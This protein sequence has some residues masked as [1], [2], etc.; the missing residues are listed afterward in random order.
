MTQSHGTRIEWTHAPGMKGETWNPVR[1]RAWE[2]QN[3]GSGKERVGWHCEHVSEGC[4]NCY[5]ESFNRFRGTG[6]DFKPSELFREER[7]QKQIINGDVKLFLDEKMLTAPLRWKK[8]R[9]V[10]LSSM[11]DVFAEF[12]SDEMLDRMFAVMALSPQHF[13]RVLTKRPER[14]RAYLEPDHDAAGRVMEVALAAGWPIPDGVFEGDED[15]GAQGFRRWPLANVGLGVSVE[16]QTTVD[17]R[18][19]LLLATPAAMRFVSAEPL[20]GPVDLRRVT[21]RDRKQFSW[22]SYDPTLDALTGNY[23]LLDGGPRD[24]HPRRLHEVIAGGESGRHARPMHPDW[25][26]SLR[27]QCAA[28]DV[29]FFFKQWGEWLPGQNDPYP[30]DGGRLGPVAHWQ[31]GGWGERD[32]RRPAAKNYIMW[33]EDGTPHPGG[34]RTHDNPFGVHRWA[35]RFGKKAAGALL[36]GVEHRGM[37]R[38]ILDHAAKFAGTSA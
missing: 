34:S 38:Q 17:E 15:R 28:A 32:P 27:D 6:H 26:R 13:F 11:T 8:P 33:E 12:V 31:D 19:P 2:I 29:P 37:A 20:L 4:R 9:S 16:D 22:L 14:M 10:F 30:P 23:P 24:P 25:A 36:D 3:D 7:A 21:H 18:I 5:A 1:A 35:A